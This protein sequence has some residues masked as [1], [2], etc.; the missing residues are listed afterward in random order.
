MTLTVGEKIGLSHASGN[1]EYRFSC[2]PSYMWN[3]SVMNVA[4]DKAL[5]NATRCLQIMCYMYSTVL[6]AK[7]DSD[8]LFCLHLQSTLFIMTMFIPSCL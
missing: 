6:P 4:I 2:E 3:D 8:V 7:S 1:F 5:N